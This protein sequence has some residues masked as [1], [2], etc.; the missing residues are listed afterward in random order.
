MSRTTA[1]ALAVLLWGCHPAESPSTTPTR[2]KEVSWLE[3]DWGGDER[4]EWTEEHWTGPRGGTM[5]GTNRHVKDEKTVF[6]D[7]LRLEGSETEVIYWAAPHGGA[8]V[9]FRLQKVEG[10]RATF[11]NPDH[12]YPQWILYELSGSTLKARIEGTENGRPK[13]TEWTWHRL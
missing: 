4:G 10:H 12:D 6:F 5:L 1:A 13:S 8:P 9:P 7:F 2:I 11:Y 3:G